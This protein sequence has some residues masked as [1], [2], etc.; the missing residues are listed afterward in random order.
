MKMIEVPV[1]VLGAALYKLRAAEARDDEERAFE[2]LEDCALD[3]RLS[4]DRHSPDQLELD[5]RVFQRR[6]IAELSELL[7]KGVKA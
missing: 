2:D 7:N 3:D 5:R 1:E 6:V 4:G